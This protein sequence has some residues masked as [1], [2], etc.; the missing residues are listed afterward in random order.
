MAPFGWLLGIYRPPGPESKVL[1]QREILTFLCCAGKWEFRRRVDFPLA[2]FALQ[3]LKSR[4]HCQVR[5]LAAFWIGG[6]NARSPNMNCR[7]K[8]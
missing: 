5:R 4:D 2:I 1:F 6:R 8:A 3:M 7:A